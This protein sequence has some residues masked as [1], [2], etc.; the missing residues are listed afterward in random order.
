MLKT[1]RTGPSGRSLAV[2]P[3]APPLFVDGAMNLIE[4]SAIT[5]NAYWLRVYRICPNFAQ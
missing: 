5:T 4:K 1:A 2:K 3:S